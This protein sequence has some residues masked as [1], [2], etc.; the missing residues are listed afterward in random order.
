M[1]RHKSCLFSVELCVRVCERVRVCA[2]AR[3]RVCACARVRVCACARVRVCARAR[4]CVCVCASVCVR[5]CVCARALALRLRR[6]NYLGHL[7]RRTLMATVVHWFKLNL[8][9]CYNKLMSVIRPV[10]QWDGADERPTPMNTYI[11]YTLHPKQRSP[12]TTRTGYTKL[13]RLRF[14]TPVCIPPVL[15]SSLLKFRINR[16]FSF[17]TFIV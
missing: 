5:A 8:P 15:C 4:A 12:Y 3:V 11:K 1:L 13:P 2:C 10:Q 14:R 6:L 9:L 7:L 17:L 16:A